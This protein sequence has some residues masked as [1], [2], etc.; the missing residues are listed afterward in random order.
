MH[1]PKI[2]MIEGITGSGKSN[3]AQWITLNLMKNNI[4][5]R[6]Y[7]ERETSNPVAPVNVIDSLLLSSIEKWKHFVNNDDMKNITTIFDGR[8]FHLSIHDALRKG[9]D[10][11]KIIEQMSAMKYLF[12]G[13]DSCL[14]YMTTDRI[15]ELFSNTF[16]ERNLEDWYVQQAEEAD[17]C[18]KNQYKGVN[19]VYQLYSEVDRI[20]KILFE[21]MDIKKIEINLTLL[22]WEH[23]S[24]MI[25]KKLGITKKIDRKIDLNIYKPIIGKYKVRFGDKDIITN[26]KEWNNQII[27][28]NHPYIVFPGFEQVLKLIPFSKNILIPRGHPL[29]FVFYEN[30]DGKIIHFKQEGLYSDFQLLNKSMIIQEP[31]IKM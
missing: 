3:L 6:W 13:T 1:I 27:V 11:E 24:D 14:V 25:L 10:S 29:Q 7:F 5:C 15:K 8:L 26:I 21:Q 2:I 19:A 9:M 20:Q 22:N 31:F 12:Q 30:S 18:I 16:E 23:E 17:F 28:E 4:D